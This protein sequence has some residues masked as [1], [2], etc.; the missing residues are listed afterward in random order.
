MSVLGSF[1]YRILCSV[2]LYSI[3]SSLL[4]EGQI[5]KQ[6]RIVFGIFLTMIL[7][8][9]AVD[10]E[11]PD[12]EGIKADFEHQAQTAVAAGE[13]YSLQQK[14]KIIKETLEAY[15]L[16][17]ADT[18]G[19]RLTV[20]VEVNDDGYPESVYLW[21]KI[22]SDIQKKMESMLSEE[23]GIAKED[24]QWNGLHMENHSAVP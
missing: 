2:V 9:S 16:D 10:F 19:C 12:F 13:A 21:G 7:L 6:L 11:L 23:L 4:P 8:S 1:T 24:Q 15:I 18:Y 3:L 22:P 20:R 5:K 17:K 14:Q